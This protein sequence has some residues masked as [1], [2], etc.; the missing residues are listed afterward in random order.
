TV[1]TPLGL[2]PSLRVLEQPGLPPLPVIGLRLHRGT[3]EL[4]APALRLHDI[5]LQAIAAHPALARNV[6]TIG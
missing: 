6:V 5:V 2:P 3:D 4:S 1:R